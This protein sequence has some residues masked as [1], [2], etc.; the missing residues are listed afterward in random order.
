[1]PAAQGHPSIKGFAAKRGS[2]SAAAIIQTGD[3]RKY[4]K[5]GSFAKVL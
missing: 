1:M 2:P 3:F 5:L 4:T